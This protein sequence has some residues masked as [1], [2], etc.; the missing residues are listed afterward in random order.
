M[1]HLTRRNPCPMCSFGGSPEVVTQF[2]SGLGAGTKNARAVGGGGDRGS[3]DPARLPRVVTG[4]VGSRIY[5]SFSSVINGSH[6]CEGCCW[7]MGKVW[8]APS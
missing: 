5:F 7:A 1:R 4:D 3:K 6:R 2:L 8:M